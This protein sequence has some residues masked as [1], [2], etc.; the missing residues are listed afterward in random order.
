MKFSH[1]DISLEITPADLKGFG[2]MLKESLIRIKV[3]K[4]KQGMIGVVVAIK[5]KNDKEQEWLESELIDQ[6]YKYLAPTS[7][8]AKFNIIKASRTQA[9]EI[10]DELTA[11]N[12]LIRSRSHLIV[13]GSVI[14]GKIKGEQSYLFRLDGLVRHL[15]ISKSNQA[16]FSKE[17]REL[18]PEKISFPE[19]ENILGFELTQKWIGYVIKYIIGIAA[20]V[21]GD[22]NLARSLYLELDIEVN[23]LQDGDNIPIINE[24]KR[25][26]PSRHREVLASL[27]SKQY[28]FYSTKREKQNLLDAKPFVRD[29][30]KISPK[31]YYALLTNAM[32]L[33]FE[34]EIDRAID[35]IKDCDAQD[36]VWR[37]SLG[38]LY[39]YKGE[40][41][42]A[43]EQYKQLPYKVFPSNVCNDSEIFMTEVISEKPE[44]VQ[45]NFFRGLLNYKYKQDYLLAKEDFIEF[46]SREESKKFSQLIELAK[47]YSEQLDRL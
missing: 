37:F 30:L 29:L 19:S 46:L 27:I 38:F 20:F 16:T 10:K 45:L 28:Y 23:A 17:F 42:L 47:K 14:Q 44:L 39:A 18:L 7:I 41:D 31:D 24:I 3:P 25:R 26:L 43:L 40:I 34:N 21:S 4:N 12:F 9:A 5:T 6:L 32:I 11:R 2:G 35:Q 1:N 33:F 22:I 8:E 13:Y 36:G 15:P